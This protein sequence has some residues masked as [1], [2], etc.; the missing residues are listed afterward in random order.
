MK[1]IVQLSKAGATE[2]VLSFYSLSEKKLLAKKEI[3]IMSEHNGFRIGM[4]VC[5]LLRNRWSKEY[6]CEF[7]NPGLDSSELD[8]LIKRISCYEECL[9]K[10]FEEHFSEYENEVEYWE[11]MTT[12]ERRD[13]VFS[14]EPITMLE[15]ERGDN[16]S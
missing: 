9:N 3:D 7:E 5:E 12:Q 15:F 13:I 1:G 6:K 14:E 16:N 4:R 8:Q 2:F 10:F 11:F